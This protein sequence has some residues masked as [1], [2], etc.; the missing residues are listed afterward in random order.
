M[1][2]GKNYKMSI[3]VEAGVELSSLWLL[4]LSLSTS[5]AQNKLGKRH[6]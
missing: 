3:S 5:F 4:F 1:K 6:P 2:L